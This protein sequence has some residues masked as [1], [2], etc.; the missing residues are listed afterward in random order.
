LRFFATAGLGTEP[1]LR[2]ELRELS[3]RGVRADRGG[4]HFEGPFEAGMR[5]CFHSSVALRVLLEVSRFDAPDED[6]LYDGVRAVDW[7]EHLSVERTLAVRAS[8]K[9]SA[10]SHTQ[11][12]AQLVKDGVVDSMR[13]KAGARPSVSRDDPDLLVSLHLAADVATLYLDLSGGALFTRGYRLAHDG[14]PLKETLAAAI[15]RLSGWD[16]VSGLVDPMCGSGTLA[17][18]AALLALARAPGTTRSSPFGF[19]RWA[20]FDEARRGQ[21]RSIAEAARQR[22]S[23]A[24]RPPRIVA[25][26]CAE[27]AV[28]TTRE[29]ASRAAVPV[30]IVRA[31]VAEPWGGGVTQLVV[32]PPY[33]ERLAS[34]PETHA[35]LA[36][37]V[38][39]HVGS[40]SGASATIVAG[41][42]EVLLAI[43]LRPSRLVR[44]MNGDLEC[45]LASYDS[46]PSP[47]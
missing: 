37:V 8:A 1:A 34:G 42:P 36:R 45:R 25:R 15:V 31:D 21:L 19:E 23:E 20:S 16:R 13:A 12:L 43:P 2:D 18:E 29:N 33:G 9:R 3:I 26:D 4:V 38:Q 17:I 46:K 41:A 30:E 44:I 7:S 5:A 11:Y 35:A 24:P 39:R 47:S 22:E 40:G 14:A 10:L 27:S 32:N 6:A 28:R